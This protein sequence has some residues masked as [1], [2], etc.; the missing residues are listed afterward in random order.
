MDLHRLC[1]FAKNEFCSWQVEVL[2]PGYYQVDLTH[3]GEGRLAWRVGIDGG[4]FIQNQQNAYTMAEAFKARFNAGREPR[5]YFWQDS[6]RNEVD[7]VY[8]QQRQLIPI[9][10]KS[11]MTWHSDLAANVRKFPRSLPD[12]KPGFVFYAGELFPPPNPTVCATLRKP[13][14]A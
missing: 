2:E 7:L 4:S 13:K 3:A 14:T 8:E 5:L 6:H 11:A 10:I 12:A 1:F 9:E